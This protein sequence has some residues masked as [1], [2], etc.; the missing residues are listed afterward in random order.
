VIPQAWEHPNEFFTTDSDSLGGAI[1]APDNLYM[2]GSFDVAP[3]EALIIEVQPPQTRYWNIAL[4]NHWHESVDYMHRPT[5]RTLEDV[6]A[7]ADGKVRFVIAQRDPGVPN[8]LDPAGNTRGFM[9]FRWL[10]ARGVAV[11]LPVV[12]RIKLTELADALPSAY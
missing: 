8:W 7:D 4:E 12:T 6:T 10:D 3:D 5:S 9:T 11:P 2:I 1:S